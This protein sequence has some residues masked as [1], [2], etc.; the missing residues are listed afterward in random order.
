MEKRITVNFEGDDVAV[1][2]EI[3][4]EDNVDSWSEAVR[5]AVRRYADLKTKRVE[6]QTEVERLKNEKQLILDQRER[7][8]ELQRYVEEEKSA[9]ERRRR[10]SLVE[11]ARWFVF[12]QDE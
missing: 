1:V 11:R 4:A 7:K 9:R 6:L 5:E 8:Q 10:A 12:G 2:E 3:H